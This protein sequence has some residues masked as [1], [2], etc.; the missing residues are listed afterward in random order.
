M[1]AFLK[2]A[3]AHP[4]LL[5]WGAAGLS[6]LVYLGVSAAGGA[7][8]FPLDDAWIHQT[9]ARN[10]GTR[11]EFAFIPGQPS[12]GSTSLLWTGLLA[13]GYTLRVEPQVWAYGLGVALLGLNAW[14]VYR[15]V[16]RW[17]PNAARASL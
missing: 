7:A 13:I 8:G 12:A 1:S 15:L 9:Y 4:A 16:Q 5:F 14:L 11:G 3:A 2:R 17:W 6:V 10:L